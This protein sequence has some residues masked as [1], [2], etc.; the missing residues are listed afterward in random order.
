VVLDIMIPYHSRPDLLRKALRSVFA[1]SSSEWE[2]TVLD[3]SEGA[4]GESTAQ[5]FRERKLKYVRRPPGKGIAANWNACLDLS[6]APLVH[7]FH[8]DDEVKPGFVA[9]VLSLYRKH[10]DAAAYFCEADV[11]DMNGRRVFSFPDWAK[12]WI[13]PNC[14]K[15]G[16]IQGERGVRSILRGSYIFCPTLCYHRELLGTSRFSTFYTF[17][18]DFDMLL[19]LLCAGHKLIGSG[20]VQYRYRRHSSESG[21]Q[22][23]SFARFVEESRVYDKFAETASQK[24]W[25]RTARVARRKTILKLHATYR[26]LESLFSMEWRRLHIGVSTLAKLQT[27][28]L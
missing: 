27:G 21:L 3:D 1:Q 20:E 22:T 5:E 11:I 10:P 8:A 6:Q 17:V 28:G 24:G 23:E 2:C 25:K 9:S 26:C 14:G 19:G 4:S 13:D 12:K 18:L 16:I 15:G 7:L